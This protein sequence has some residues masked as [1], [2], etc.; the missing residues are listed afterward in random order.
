MFETGPNFMWLEIN[1]IWVQ[2]CSHGSNAEKSFPTITVKIR[3]ESILYIIYF[4][5][6]LGDF[7]KTT[8]ILSK[9]T[10]NWHFC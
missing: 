1:V 3:F 6:Q 7:I 8:M 5:I 9:N 2:K 4:S 10:L